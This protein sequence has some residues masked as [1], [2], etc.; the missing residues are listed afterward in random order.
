MSTTRP[1]LA[2]ALA[3]LVITACNDSTPEVK[4]MRAESV[5]E[6]P[7]PPPAAPM[8]PPAPIPVTTTL[9]NDRVI[10]IGNAARE[11]EAAPEQID[12]ILAGHGMD[13]TAFES[14]VA[15]IARDPWMT[16]LYIAAL[17]Q[18]NPKS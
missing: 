10:E 14:A 17:S 5:K 9:D 13:R 1:L 11:I 4:S 8:I 16:D 12:A 15:L 3:A 7:P 6:A 2:C 18:K